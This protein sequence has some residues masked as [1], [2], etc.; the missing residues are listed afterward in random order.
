MA[1]GF[2]G[3][4]RCFA[5]A[6]YDKENPDNIILFTGGHHTGRFYAVGEVL[7]NKS[8]PAMPIEWLPRPVLTVDEQ[9][10]RENGLSYEE[11]HM[12]VSHRRDT[13]FF[14]GMTLYKNKW[15]A[16]YGGSEYYACLATPDDVRI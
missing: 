16:I 13:I 3:G 7:F 5:L 14:T 6:E 11:P 8:N 4:E 12:P 1:S 9:Y 15:W 10:P 2:P